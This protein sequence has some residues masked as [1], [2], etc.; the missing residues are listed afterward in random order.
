M[1]ITSLR[2]EAV[3]FTRLSEADLRIAKAIAEQ[4]PSDQP[5]TV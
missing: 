4:S 3:G 2:G 5:G 1:G